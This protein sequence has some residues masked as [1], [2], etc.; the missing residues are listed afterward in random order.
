MALR[1][2]HLLKALIILAAVALDCVAS[3]AFACSCEKAPEPRGLQG[4]QAVFVG[5]VERIEDLGQG[6]VI[7]FALVERLWGEPGATP[8]IVTG[9]GDSDCGFPFRPGQ[10][11][12]VYGYGPRLFLARP[13]VWPALAP[14]RGHALETDRCTASL[15]LERAQDR[16]TRLREFVEHAH[17]SGQEYHFN[18]HW[19]G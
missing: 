5:K 7:H 4:A 17:A 8:T 11:Y 16:L 15:P 12:L 3:A 9:E 2:S 6:R 1:S 14:L 19:P 10:S 13:D 18:A